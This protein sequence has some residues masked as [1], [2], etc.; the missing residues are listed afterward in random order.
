[1]VK[2][3]KINLWL[4]AAIASLLYNNI[5]LTKNQSEHNWDVT[6]Q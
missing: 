6:M 2:Q 3:I 1:M 5:K 4:E